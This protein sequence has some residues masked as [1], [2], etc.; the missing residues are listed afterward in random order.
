MDLTSAGYTATHLFAIVLGVVLLVRGRKLYWL[1]LGGVGFF[2]GLW[3]ASHF[4]D[5]QTGGLGLGIGFLV[6]VLGAYLTTA[7]QRFAVALGGFAI[8]GALAYRATVWLAPS[9][10]LQPGPWWLLVALLGAMV[11]S[12]FAAMLFEASLVALTALLGAL[13]I[14]R[15]SLLG[16]PHESW[17]FLILLFVGMLAQSGGREKRRGSRD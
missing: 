12:F 7:A 4:L 15:A 9:L 6:G 5:L 10:D 16:P 1:A 17:L 13:L 14:A 3:L 8:G 11:G 2:L